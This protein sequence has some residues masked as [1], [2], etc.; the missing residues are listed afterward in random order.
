MA[1]KLK[2]YGFNNLTKALSFNIYDVCYAKTEREQQDYIAYIDEQYNSERLTTILTNLTDMIG[3]TVLNISKQDYEPQGASVT[4]LIAERP[5]PG[6]TQVA[7][8]DKSHVTVH[9]YPEYHP[10]TCLATF[11]VDIDVATCGEITPLSTLD[12]LISSFDS[13]IITMDYRVRGFTRDM[14]GQKLFMDHPVASIQDYIDP[15]TLR[16]YDAVDINVYSANLFH[17]RMMLK[18]IDLQNYL[19]KTDVYEL[20]P[21]VRLEI[22]NNIRR[23]MI[24]IFS[25]RNIY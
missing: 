18:D 20:P 4:I 6:E 5:V 16:R 24:E 25:G 3:A 10:E 21:M 23:E 19:F 8:L 15:I 1:E 11:R 17:T 13:D 9:T 22:M 7:H 12:Y 2:L 14:N